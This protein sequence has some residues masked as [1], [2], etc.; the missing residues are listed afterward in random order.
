[1]F[2]LIKDYI[3]LFRPKHWTKNLLVFAG[4]LFSFSF[5]ISSIKLAFYGFILFSLTS[6]IVYIINDILDKEKDKLHPKKKS[7][8]IPAG[9]IKELNAVILGLIIF[10]IVFLI[11]YLLNIKFFLILLIY[12][13]INVLYSYFLKNVVI[14]DLFSIAVGFILRA[15]SG[16]FLINVKLSDWFILAT[17]FISLF[18]AV[19]KRRHEIL[20]IEE[21]AKRNVLQHYNTELI[22]IL[23]GIF[24][25]GTIITY[26]IYVLMEHPEFMP[27]LIFVIYGILRYLYIVYKKEEGGE[28]EKILLNDTHILLTV[29]FFVIFIIIIHLWG[30]YY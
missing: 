16:V 20:F 1:M 29:L 14:L 7:R 15:I 21:D 26:S 10:V 5:D 23:I 25:T 13:I 28:P 11:S 30:L 18:L 8:P 19:C 6:G 9:R 3:S 2:S 17:L 22:N 27:S 12:F 24:S 4:L